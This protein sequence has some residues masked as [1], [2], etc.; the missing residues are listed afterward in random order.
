MRRRGMKLLTLGLFVTTALIGCNPDDATVLKEDAQKL[1][2]DLVPAIANAGLATKVNTH[3][4]LHKGVTMT[5]LHIE[6]KNKTVKVGGYVKDE[7]MKRLVISIIKETTGVEKVEESL[8]IK[9]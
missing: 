9:P 3:L 2:K 4:L 1:G 8:R 6:T 5:G 7:K